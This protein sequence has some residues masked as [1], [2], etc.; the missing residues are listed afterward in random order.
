ML[1][2][3]ASISVS[4]EQ[5]NEIDVPSYHYI[6]QSTLVNI[7]YACSISDC[8]K[9]NFGIP[10]LELPSNCSCLILRSNFS[11]GEKQF[12]NVMTQTQII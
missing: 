2:S 1:F 8:L 7:E 12:L 6:V 4:S 5:F 3:F 9:P 10:K 11:L